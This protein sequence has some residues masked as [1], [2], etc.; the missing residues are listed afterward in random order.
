VVAVSHVAI[1]RVAVHNVAA[2]EANATVPAAPPGS[3]ASVRVADVP[4]ATL[5]GVALAVNDVVARVT[6][7]TVDAAEPAKFASPE[8]VAM[9]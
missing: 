2:P 3:P 7:N 6:W 8:Y 1:G 5:A 9:T 4:Y